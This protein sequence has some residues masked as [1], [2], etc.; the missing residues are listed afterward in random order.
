MK[1]FLLGNTDVELVSCRFSRVNLI[2][3]IV[4]CRLPSSWRKSCE[5]YVWYDNEWGY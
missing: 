2:V 3:S 5:D 1:E 4:D